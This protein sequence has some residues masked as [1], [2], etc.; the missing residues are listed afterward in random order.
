MTTTLRMLKCEMAEVCRLLFFVSILI[1]CSVSEITYTNDW[2]VEVYGSQD[3]A[4]RLAA[5][6][7]FVNLGNVNFVTLLHL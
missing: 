6:S 1:V 5:R 3:E 4:N 7:G 2:A